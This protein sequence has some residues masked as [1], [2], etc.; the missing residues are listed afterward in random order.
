MLSGVSLEVPKS[1]KIEVPGYGA[2][3]DG[4][5]IIQVGELFLWRRKLG[6]ILRNWATG[7]G[8]ISDGADMKDVGSIS[9]GAD[10]LR[11]PKCSLESLWTE[12]I[13]TKIWTE[14]PLFFVAKTC[15]SRIDNNTWI[16]HVDLT[17]HTRFVHKSITHTI[18]KP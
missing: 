13:L 12:S 14:P 7:V 16:T 15:N 3:C 8:S 5:D 4:A 18:H 17:I 10:L 9:D 6:A 11:H 2:N 1:K